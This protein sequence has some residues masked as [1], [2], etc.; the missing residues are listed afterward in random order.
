V[1]DKGNQ[2]TDSITNLYSGSS[3]PFAEVEDSITSNEN[4]EIIIPA[5]WRL[6]NDLENGCQCFINIVTGAKVSS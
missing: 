4:S 2:I 6:E 5:G 1:Q 3:S